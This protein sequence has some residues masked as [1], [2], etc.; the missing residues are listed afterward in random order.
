VA[1]T[2]RKYDIHRI[3]KRR[4]AGIMPDI[5][6]KIHI[7]VAEDDPFGLH[8]PVQMLQKTIKTKNM[9]GIE[10]Q[11]L[12]DGGHDLWSDKIRKEIFTEINSKI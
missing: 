7:Y 6:D 1:R 11:I 4:W 9:R 8:I 3:I 5:K 10:V 2:W 12:P